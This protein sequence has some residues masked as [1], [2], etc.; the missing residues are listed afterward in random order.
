MRSASLLHARAETHMNLGV[1][2][3]D[4]KQIDWAIQAFKVAAELA[5]RHPFPHRCL[6]R[7]YRRAK[8]DLDSARHHAALAMKLRKQLHDAGI[9]PRDERRS[10]PV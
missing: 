5:P 4:L 9:T 10:V 1:A 7:L 3:A 2:L 6:A 8:K